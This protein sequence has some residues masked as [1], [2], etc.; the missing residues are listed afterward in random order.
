MHIYRNCCFFCVHFLGV[1]SAVDQ[2]TNGKINGI[3]DRCS[4]LPN[5]KMLLNENCLSIRS[6]IMK[7]GEIALISIALIFNNQ[8]VIYSI[9]VIFVGARYG[10]NSIAG[11]TCEQVR[12]TG[13]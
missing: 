2:N 4:L 1:P 7:Q 3:I 5:R 9:L 10:S 12:K 13:I 8:Q 6:T 11:R